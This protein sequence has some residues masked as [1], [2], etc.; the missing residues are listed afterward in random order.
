MLFNE[1]LQNVNKES[2]TLID[3]ISRFIELSVDLN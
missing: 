2:F 3:K 1:K